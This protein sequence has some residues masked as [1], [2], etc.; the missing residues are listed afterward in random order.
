MPED[1]MRNWLFVVVALAAVFAPVRALSQPVLRAGATLVYA[2]GDVYLNDQAVEPNRSRVVLPDS[3]VL[4]TR[5][6]RAAIALKRGGVLF[7]DAGSSVRILGN[8]VYNFNRIE[9]LTGSAIVVSQTSSPLVECENETRLS[10][11]GIFR[12][13]VQ[14]LNATERQCRFRVFEGAAAVPLVSV[15]NAL[16][17]GQTMNCNRR[18]GDMIPTMEFSREQLDEFDQWARRIHESLK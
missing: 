15:T 7:L 18:C 9:V 8:G 12:F 16:R 11:A 3:A 10:D 2:E 4:S 5:Q 6:G 13:D 17:A 1:T 14:R